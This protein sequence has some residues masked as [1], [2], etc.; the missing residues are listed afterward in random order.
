M[1]K[2]LEEFKIKG[3]IKSKLSN[4]IWKVG[5]ISSSI[6]YCINTIYA[7]K[8]YFNILSYF[9]TLIILFIISEIIFIKNTSKKLNIKFSFKQLV[10]IQYI[11]EIYNKINE[12]QKKWITNYCKKNKLNNINKL[13]IL[14]SEIKNEED[15][16]TIKYIN[17]III[18]TLSLTIWEIAIQKMVE[19][20]GFWNMLP[21]AIVLVIGIS[22][23]IGCVRK[24][25]I[26]DKK[27][28]MEFEKFS[29]KQRLKELIMYRMLKTNK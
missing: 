23:F 9:L 1:Q 8:Y 21:T 13:N 11:R 4:F 15:I 17:L 10:N 28:F 20:I 3:A 7:N 18:G 19:R 29:N 6:F 12:Y 24:E 25:F 26:E 16:T 22:F 14:M 2:I 5:V 27:F